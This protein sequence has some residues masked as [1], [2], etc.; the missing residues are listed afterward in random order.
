MPATEHNSI[1]SEFD[2]FERMFEMIVNKVRKY[3][4][5]ARKP[6]AK[7]DK[8]CERVDVITIVQ[9]KTKA[10]QSNMLRG[11]TC[12]DECT[13]NFNESRE[14]LKQNT[15]NFA[16]IL[17]AVIKNS[18]ASTAYF[19]VLPQTPRHKR[20]PILILSVAPMLM[21]PPSRSASTSPSAIPVRADFSSLR[22]RARFPHAPR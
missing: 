9:I 6:E 11:L 13:S 15:L 7:T 8:Q 16:R 4:A 22:S 20:N 21:R 17:C 3:S 12:K 2:V 10:M 18:L 19:F 14:R 5:N 1:G